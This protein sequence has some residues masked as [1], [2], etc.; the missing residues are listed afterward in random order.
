VGG[1][2]IYGVDSA[3]FSNRSVPYLP[4][5]ELSYE[6]ASVILF[7][8]LRW[9]KLIGGNRERFFHSFCTRDGYG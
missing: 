4:S 9:C 7:P 6:K 1:M 2:I 3:F 8:S 5:Q